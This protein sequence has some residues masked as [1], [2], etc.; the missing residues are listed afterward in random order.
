MARWDGPSWPE[1][2]SYR[3]RRS[4]TGRDQNGLLFDLG[5]VPIVA[6]ILNVLNMGSGEDSLDFLGFLTLPPT[7]SPL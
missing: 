5:N 2:M 4:I 1:A 6:E 7:T 3:S